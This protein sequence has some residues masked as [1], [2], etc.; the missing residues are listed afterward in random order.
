MKRRREQWIARTIRGGRMAQKQGLQCFDTNGNALLDITD[1]LTRVLGVVITNEKDGFV[2]DDNLLDGVPWFAK[3]NIQGDKSI[4]YRDSWAVLEIAV[5]GNV[6]SY[7]YRYV[8]NYYNGSSNKINAKI[9]YGV[10]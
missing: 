10:M 4:P 7:A 1:R 2:I 9:I 8:E 5:T 3:I 6:L